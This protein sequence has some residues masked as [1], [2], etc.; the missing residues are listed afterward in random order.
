R[1][2]ARDPSAP[3][4]PLHVRSS[5]ASGI[6]Q[7]PIL[8]EDPYGFLA[9]TRALAAGWSHF[10]AGARRV[11]CTMLAA[12]GCACLT[13]WGAGRGWEFRG[14]RGGRVGL[15]GG[16]P[17][18]GGSAVRLC[19][20][21]LEHVAVRISEIK[22]A[23]ATTAIDLHIV[24]RAGSTAVRDALGTDAVEDAVKLRF[25]DLE[26][27]VVTLEL[28]IIVEIEG[29]R[30]VDPQLREVRERTFIAQT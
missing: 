21:H 1:H 15:A 9:S 28:R 11:R 19:R 22:T 26:G 3:V 29:Q 5:G 10:V 20:Q 4:A 13:L 30:V 24:E 18:I 25:I 23:S 14:R 12:M 6:S 8:R 16:S 7:K 17:E 27:V 2:R